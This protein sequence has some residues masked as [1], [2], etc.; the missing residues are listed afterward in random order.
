LETVDGLVHRNPPSRLFRISLVP[1]PISADRT[2]LRIIAGQATPQKALL[3]AVV[4]D[5]DARA[6]EFGAAAK[7]PSDLDPFGDGGEAKPVVERLGDPAVAR[8]NVAEQNAAMMIGHGVAVV[9]IDRPAHELER[10][11]GS[12][13]LIGVAPPID[14]AGEQFALQLGDPAR[15]GPNAAFRDQ[16]E[17]VG[18]TPVL[19]LLPHMRRPGRAHVDHA[20]ASIEASSSHSAPMIERPPD[21]SGTMP[22]TSSASVDVTGPDDRIMTLFS[23]VVAYRLHLW[24]RPGASSPATTFRAA[25]EQAGV[26]VQVAYKPM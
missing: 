4:E 20:D 1:W 13:V 19:D 8:G 25:A 23:P 2:G 24:P 15:I 16:G 3:A 26:F 14:A 10:L 11:A 5:D 18:P 7:D 22:A 6:D 9:L 12:N 17:C 21:I